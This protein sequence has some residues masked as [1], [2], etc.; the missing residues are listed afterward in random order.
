MSAP[1][2][3]PGPPPRPRKPFCKRY[4]IPLF[5]LSL[6]LILFIVFYIRGTWSDSEPRDP[7][8][9]SEGIICRLYQ[10]PEGDWQVRC[11]MVLDDPPEKVWDVVTDYDHF[12]DIFPTLES[13]S[14]G[15]ISGGIRNWEVH[16]S[17][18]ARS[19]IGTWPFDIDVQNEVEP[20]GG[21][22]HWEGESGDVKKIA[23][24]WTVTPAGEGKTLL[25]YAS[26][27][28]IKHYPKW[29]VVNALLWRQPKVMQAVADWLDKSKE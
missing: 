18:S 29:V 11:S 1:A 15:P 9:S 7:K 24:S 4:A 3:R 8:S 23:G 17:G 20:R 5:L 28:D 21:H 19:A 14:A 2:P 12:T 27:I 16:L 13:C 25:V 22:S 26:H 6:L 10:P